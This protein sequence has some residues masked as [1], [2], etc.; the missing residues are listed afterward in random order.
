MFAG[1]G[2]MAAGQAFLAMAGPVGWA[3]GGAALV[4][5]GLMANNKNKKIAEKAERQTKEL[6][7]EMYS[8][9][10]INMKV[11]SEMKA[12]V[13]LNEG[14]KKVLETMQRMGH[15]DYLKLTPAE[16]DILMQ[17]INDANTLSV[18]IG[19]KLV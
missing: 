5:G 4:G 14:V 11:C 10:Q 12:V 13:M 16:K 9:N 8:L 15:R 2:G 17:L 19:A 1:G 18:R 3:I 6:K 7:K